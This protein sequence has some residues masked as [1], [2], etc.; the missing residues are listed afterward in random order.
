M[1]SFGEGDVIMNL[2]EQVL[3]NDVKRSSVVQRII[4]G[5][6]GGTFEKE[7]AEGERPARQVAQEAEGPARQASPPHLEEACAC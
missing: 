5:F 1:S 3:Q 4:L 2:P 6:N 7:A